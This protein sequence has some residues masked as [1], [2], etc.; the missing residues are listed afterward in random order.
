MDEL[1]YLHTAKVYHGIIVA[2]KGGSVDIDLKARLGKFS[3]PMRMLISENPPQL[4]QEVAFY[5]S[6]PEVISE[7]IDEK[8]LDNINRKLED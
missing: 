4:G 6:Y 7:E 5:L 2:I 8:Y 1:K 3:I